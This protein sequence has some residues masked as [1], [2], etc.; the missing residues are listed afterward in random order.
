[1]RYDHES[2][3]VVMAT[4]TMLLTVRAEVVVGTI[5]VGKMMAT[6]DNNILSMHRTLSDT[7]CKRPDIIRIR[8]VLYDMRV[9]EW[10]NGGEKSHQSHDALPL[11]I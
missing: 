2:M 11:I 1:M 9:S 7:G 6:V 4:A 3:V 10:I 8:C 5:P